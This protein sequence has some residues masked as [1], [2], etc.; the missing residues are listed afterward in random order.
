[1]PDVLRRDRPMHLGGG[2]DGVGHRLE[3]RQQPVAQALDEDAVMAR[4]Y[5]RR[6]DADEVRPSA[7]RGGLVLSH[8][9]HRFHEID[10]QD[11][12]LLAY[13]QDACVGRDRSLGAVGLLSVF[14]GHFNL[15]TQP[16]DVH[17]ILW[18][19]GPSDWAKK[20]IM[21]GHHQMTY[22]RNC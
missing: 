6:G 11:D 13:Q 16:R 8:E 1:M 21:K 22:S 14:F 7:N 5:L 12:G 10:Q 15:A 18:N 17:L 20:D 4:Q 3:T 19:R 9:P 2:I